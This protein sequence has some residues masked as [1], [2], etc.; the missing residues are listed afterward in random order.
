M[1]LTSMTLSAAWQDVDAGRREPADPGR[2]RA[3][4]AVRR[5]SRLVR[6]LRVLL[7]VG[8]VLAVAGLIVK[9]QLSFPGDLDLAGARLSVTRNSV[10][11]EGPRLTGFDGDRREY[12]MS[13]ERAIQPLATPAQ[14]RLE[15]IVA[16]VTTAGQGSTA[17]TAEA[18]DYDH[19]KR[20]I[21]LLG[22]IVIDSAEGYRLTMADADVDFAAETMITDRPI[23][24][25][26][27]DSEIAGDRLFVSEGGKRIVIE[28]R[29]RT[30]LMPPKRT[31]PAAPAEE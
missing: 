28:G 23:V 14:V 1:M 21:R 17:I 9:A 22:P 27:G 19:D 24:I 6:L 10:I 13:A 29:V 3:F 20:T 4:L 11:M 8:A 5:H 2:A 12:S 16:K 18:G 26:Y 15:E 31:V 30:V 7:P 25:G